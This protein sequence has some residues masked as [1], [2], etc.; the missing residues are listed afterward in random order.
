MTEDGSVGV[1]EAFRRAI[2]PLVTRHPSL[3]T[4]VLIHGSAIKS[5]GNPWRFNYLR[6]SNRR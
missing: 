4:A 2:G 6:F 3:V 5:Y 1:I